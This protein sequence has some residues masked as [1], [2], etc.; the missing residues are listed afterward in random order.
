MGIE[1]G[2]TK[3]EEF[4]RNTEPWRNIEDQGKFGTK[5]LR[6]KLAQL[7]MKLIHSSFEDII[8][9]MKDRRDE[10]AQELKALGDLPSTLMEKR[11]LF[12]NVREEIHDGIGAETLNGRLSTL[13]SS[14]FAMR[15]SA[16][17]HS[18]SKEFQRELNSSR[19]ANISCIEVGS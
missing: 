5:H 14:A 11:A 16:E 15:P 18:A 12:R 10:S 7:Q 9:E 17:F 19:L 13:H 1:E 6:K 8:S 3:E 2:L 4:F